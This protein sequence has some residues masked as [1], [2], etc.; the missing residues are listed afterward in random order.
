MFIDINKIHPDGVVVDDD[1]RLPDLEGPGGET[2][3]VDRARLRARAV[4]GRRGVELTG[5]L[6]AS[7]HLPCSRCL[8]S[9]PVDIASEFFLTLV[10]EAVEFSAGDAEVKEEDATL[11]Y[12]EEGQADLRKVAAE[13]IYLNLPLKLICSDDCR[14][15]CPVCGA[16]RNQTDCEC[17]VDSV[18]PRLAPL[19]QFK[20]R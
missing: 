6:D 4:P 10:P 1:L 9:R 3:P 19:R 11:F 14:G 18:D 5:R 8:Q 17:K 15:L 16:N 7:V 12:V 20:S 2:L 13:Q